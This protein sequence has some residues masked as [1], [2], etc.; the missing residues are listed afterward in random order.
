[1]TGIVAAL[2]AGIA[3]GEDPKRTER[4]RDHLSSTATAAADVQSTTTDFLS[5]DEWRRLPRE[6]RRRR[7]RGSNIARYE[8]SGKPSI[9]KLAEYLAKYKDIVIYDARLAHF[10][11]QARHVEGTTGS[12]ELTGEVSVPQYKS[13]IESTLGQLGFKVEKNSISVLPEAGLGKEVFAYATT[14]AATLRKEPRVNAEQVNSVPLG[15]W[16]RLLR[17]SRPTDITNTPGRGSRGAP[18]VLATDVKWFL[19]QS[20]E[21][22]LGYVRSDQVSRTSDYRLPDAILAVPTTVTVEGRK[23]AAPSGTSLNRDS[24]GSYTIPGLDVPVEA[25]AK[26]IETSKPSFTEEEVLEVSQPLMNTRYEWG[27][28]TDKGIDCSGFTQFLFKSHGIFLPRDA[29]EQAIVGQ[30]V[31]FGKDVEHKAQPGDV[32]FFV[33]ENG[34]INHVGISLGGGKL[35]HSSGHGVHISTLRKESDEESGRSLI[36]RIIFARR[37]LSR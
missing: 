1:M 22:Y 12:V 24:N 30:I 28:V 27:G 6:E 29:E 21:A 7:S 32:I 23:V 8:S 4:G 3:S 20:P 5:D 34:K 19:A 9:E 37:V 25:N 17:E 31:A 18:E 13:G 11:V 15:G 10:D 35:I 14:T 16:I 2:I 33:G 26:V 36:D